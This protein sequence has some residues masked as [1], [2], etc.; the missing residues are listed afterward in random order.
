M[1]DTN[2]HIAELRRRLQD[3]IVILDG[4]MGTMIQEL[5]L[6]E[7]DFR[8][9]RFKDHGRELRG[10]NDLLN[11][12]RPEAILD[13]HR[14]FLQAGAEILKA[15]TFNSTRIA[16]KDYELSPMARELNEAGARLA[17]RAA[18]EAMADAPRAAG[19]NNSFH[20]VSLQADFSS[21]FFRQGNQL[22]DAVYE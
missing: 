14:A 22:L 6:Q 21:V 10:N 12:T 7:A 15:N 16:Q 4:A 5:S 11:L 3:H 13:I 8:G 20:R 1:S 17:R 19:N 9:E 2:T 18:D